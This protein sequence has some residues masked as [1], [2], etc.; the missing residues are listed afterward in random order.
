MSLD[1]GTLTGYLELDESAVGDAVGRAL[2]HIKSFATKGVVIAGAAGLAI[3]GAIGSSIV[4]GMN[5]EDG[6]D[7]L[8]AELAL[9][10][11]QSAR[12]GQV[13]GRLFA[14]NYGD[15]MDGVN[16]AVSAVMTSIDGMASGSSSALQ[17]AA[18]DAL[19]FASV[20]DIDVSRAAQIAGQAV[21]TG[22]ADNATQAFDLIIAA[23]Q[24]VPKAVREDVLDAADEYGQFFASLGY[25]GQQAFSLLVDASAKGM[26]GIDKAGDAVKEFTIRSTDMS[27]SSKAAYKTIGLDAQTMANDILAGGSK[28]QSATQKIIAGLL[29]IKDPA[30]QGQAAIALF[31]TPLEDLNTSEIPKFLK[32]LKGGSDAMDGFG[33]ASKRMDTTL[34]GNAIKSL[35]TLRRQATVAFYTLGNWALP[36]VNQL[37]AAMSSN[38]A[39]AL[40][41]VVATL[42]DVWSISKNVFGFLGGHQTTIMVIASII[43]A[44][45]VPAFIAWGVQAALAGA[46]SVAAF[47]A[48]KVGAAQSAA[49]HVISLTLITVSW[50][51]A[52][53]QAIISAARIAGAWLLSKVQVAGTIALYGVAFAMMAAGWLA[54]AAA[55]MA[56]AATMAA[57]WLI[58]IWPI[59]LAVAAIVAVVIL[60]I[61][62][63]DQIKS[64]TSAA[65]N[66]I[67]NIVSSV[68]GAV[69]GFVR[70]NW[71]L[72]LA[73][74]TGPLGLIVLAVSKNLG[75]IKAFFSAA[76]SA[77]RAGASAAWNGIT[78][79]ISGG[80][81]TIV[82]AVRSIP[83]KL[84]ALVSSFGSAGKALISAFVNGMKNAGGIITGIAG[85]VWSAVKGLL[86]S[87]IGKLR[88]ALNFSI[89][90]P[91]PNINVNVGNS[92]PYLAE[93]G[94]V[95]RPTIAM[96]GEAGPEAVVPLSG[97]NGANARNALG[98]GGP[99]G[100][101]TKATLTEEDRNLLRE[102][103]EAAWALADRDQYLSIDGRQAGM[104][105]KAGEHAAGRL[106]RR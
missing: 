64:A 45:L 67:K 103:T 44:I 47:L 63:W 57:A 80:A 56:G 40:V 42:Q 16:E 81:A 94:Y 77:V 37:A 87:A 7:K 71:P 26:Y 38:F 61:K 13:A 31:G 105:Y 34:N 8:A 11:P 28:A 74:I 97:R 43:G 79:I 41:T 1:L 22:L 89:D 35:S 17:A 53:V 91:G 100:S 36:K 69:V 101:D 27:A 46:R 54:S 24:R 50:I 2:E 75:R 92:I 62:Y 3:A 90:I 58:A 52:G 30:A 72:L 6:R 86:N 18:V 104:L 51:R 9:T 55:S 95:D 88:S 106:G 21:R 76:W 5:L 19:N 99:V 49:M 14:Q 59:A 102:F 85:N 82:S 32:S 20:F 25:S 96:I 73:I 23:S 70:N 15:S 10:E 29:A 84:R 65:W 93:G 98:V 83:G 68:V 66:W 39:P 48:A 33:G 60:V 78:G 4:A 12:I